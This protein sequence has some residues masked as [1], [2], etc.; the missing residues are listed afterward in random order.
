MYIREA[1]KYG[2]HKLRDASVDSYTLAAEL[3]LLDALQRE[4][5]WLYSHPE[6]Q[7]TPD[8]EQK[9]VGSVQRRISGEPIQHITGHQ[10]FWSLDF[11]VS[12]DVLIPRPETE[13]L[14]E[15]ALDRLAVREIQNGRPQKNNGEGLLV[16][17]V[18]TG[19]GCIAIALAKEL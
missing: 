15:V 18:G 14:I 2:I 3:L 16:A 11:A 6:E 10:E 12:P 5:A 19:S 4:R 17:D 13:H 9:Y 8:Q 7:L 1:L